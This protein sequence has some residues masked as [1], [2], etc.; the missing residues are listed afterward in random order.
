M[1]SNL[2]VTMGLGGAPASPPIESVRIIPLITEREGFEV[3]R[4]KIVEI[5][6]LET[7]IQQEQAT[8]RGYDPDDWKFLVYRERLNPWEMYR[9]ADFF[10]S[11]VNVWYDNDFFDLSC[12]NMSFQQKTK[13]RFNVDC[14]ACAVATETEAGQ[15]VSDEAAALG[16]HKIARIVRRILMHDKYLKLGL[17]EGKLVWTRWLA[18]RQIMRPPSG[19]PSIQRVMCMRLGFDVELNET[20]TIEEEQTADFI[21]VKYHN[22][23]DGQLVAELNHEVQI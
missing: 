16:A 2:L 21:N 3:V 17:E 9:N 14:Y 23:T 6:A 7:A 1:A 11:M 12:S 20:V 15:I 5:L 18:D 13:S 22:G 10:V 8:A 19:D 4:D